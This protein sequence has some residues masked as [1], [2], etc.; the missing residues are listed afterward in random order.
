[1]IQQLVV[2]NTK[3]ANFLDTVDVNTPREKVHWMWCTTK[4]SDTKY[5]FYQSNLL[6]VMF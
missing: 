4:N 2:T 5:E 3:C 1:M 6:I